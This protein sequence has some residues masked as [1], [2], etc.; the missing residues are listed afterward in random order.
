MGRKMKLF[1]KE[2]IKIKYVSFDKE[3]CLQELANI[4]FENK[5]VTDYDQYIKEIMERENLVS[6]GM[7]KGIAIPHARTD[8]ANELKVLVCLMDNELDFESLD[9][10]PVR[11]IFML[12]VP[13]DMKDE[14]MTVLKQL[15]F[16]LN[17]KNNRN[18]LLACESVDEVY[19]ILKGVENEI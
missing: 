4:M 14:Y 2:L 7:G 11:I 1:S 12:A 17:D 8:V 3:Q 16:F 13:K 18:N 5:V 6:T 15:S 9:K 19:N 10:K